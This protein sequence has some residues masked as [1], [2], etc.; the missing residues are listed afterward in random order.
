M[1]EAFLQACGVDPA[2]ELEVES[3]TSARSIRYC[4]RQ[5]FAIIGRHPAADVYLDA[6]GIR[7][8]HVYLQALEGRIA[9]INVSQ[10]S[11]FASEDHEVEDF[12]WL[13]KERVIQ[14][15]SK[16]IKVL[17]D[18][19]EQ[20]AATAT[21]SN[22]LQSGSAW[23]VFGPRIALEL[24]NDEVPGSLETWVID[25]V[26]TLVGRAARCAIQLSDENISNVHCSLVL[27]NSGLW[28][29]DLLGRDGILINE[30]PVRAGL[31]GIDDELRLGP[32]RIRWQE[33]AKWLEIPT[34]DSAFVP[35]TPASDFDLTVAVPARGEAA[36]DSQGQVRSYHTPWPQDADQANLLEELMDQ[37]QEMNDP[38]FKQHQ[39]M[40]SR[41]I[42]SFSRMSETE[43]NEVKKE[44]ANLRRVRQQVQSAQQTDEPGCDSESAP[45][46]PAVDTTF[47]TDVLLDT[48]SRMSV[49]DPV[50]TDPPSR[51]ATTLLQKSDTSVFRIPKKTGDLFEH[52][53]IATEQYAVTS[54]QVL[55]AW[56]DAETE[57]LSPGVMQDTQS[58]KGEAAEDTLEITY[59]YD[60]N[61]HEVKHPIS[62]EF[63]PFVPSRPEADHPATDTEKAAHLWLH[64][65]IDV[66]QEEQSSIW[67]K[68]SQFFFGK[69]SW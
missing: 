30:R 11:S 19:G 64:D 7:P 51:P 6:D 68:L 32:F 48:R 59:G 36:T 26:I 10:I 52:A 45:G 3:S 4:L 60:P 41:L 2:L 37:F 22:P 34:E 17:D 47:S 44:L 1:M 46:S 55:P 28:V 18:G 43:R 54:E 69:S 56:S 65:R 9:C 15:G 21:I 63:K 5:P 23:E 49:S 42:E 57:L 67:Q 16:H 61:E 39:H 62:L 29:V 24:H 33:P 66:L 25:R 12:C 40:L 13:P 27:T 31:L 35:L 14:I 53:S 20:A 8:R 38:L 50:T 58:L